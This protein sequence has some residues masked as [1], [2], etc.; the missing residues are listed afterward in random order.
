MRGKKL[1]NK[2]IDGASG[3]EIGSGDSS[4]SRRVGVR[5]GA[6]GGVDIVA[7]ME[8]V[9]RGG[10]APCGNLKSVLEL[11]SGNGGVRKV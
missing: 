10:I 2:Q 4:R 8:V 7:G 5:G 3:E 9:D 11:L 1:L 6:R